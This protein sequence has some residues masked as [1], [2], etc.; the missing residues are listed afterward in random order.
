[1]KTEEIKQPFTKKK[2]EEIK[3]ELNGPMKENRVG[4]TF[5]EKR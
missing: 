4:F 2:E 5:S 3:Q 1:L